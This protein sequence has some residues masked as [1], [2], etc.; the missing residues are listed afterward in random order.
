METWFSPCFCEFAFSPW[1]REHRKA[2]NQWGIA[3]GKC[4]FGKA[5]R[6]TGSRW[7]I[8]KPGNGEPK[9][10]ERGFFLCKATALGFRVICWWNCPRKGRWWQAL[11]RE[12]RTLAG[13]NSTAAQV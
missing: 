6:R 13:R 2:R 10:M 7:P 5:L 8:T 11:A 9:A 12:R 3:D 1:L 4:P